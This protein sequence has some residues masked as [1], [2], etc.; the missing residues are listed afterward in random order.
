[1]EVQ[2]LLQLAISLV[3]SK[4][5]VSHIIQDLGYSKV[6]IRWVPWSLTVKHKTERKAISSKL[7]A[8]FQV[9]EQ[10]FLSWIVTA[11]ETWVHHFEPE[12]KRQWHHPQSPQKKKFKV[13]ISGPG[14]EHC[15]LG[16]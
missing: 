15:L 16:L 8:R 2:D 7:L 11:D 10:T 1:M 6:C 3:I 12:T 9:Q 13:S 4:G 5:S 14:R